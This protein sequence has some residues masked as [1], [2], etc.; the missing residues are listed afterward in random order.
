MEGN[1]P[2]EKRGFLTKTEVSCVT[3]VTPIWT[4]SPWQ[5]GLCLECLFAKVANST[6]TVDEHLLLE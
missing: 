3:N 4:V 5:G 1:A 2:K 6:K